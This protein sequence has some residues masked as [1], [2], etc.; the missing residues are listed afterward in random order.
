MRLTK[1]QRR[2]MAEAR[3]GRVCILPNG[4]RSRFTPGA[5][6]VGP[7]WMTARV[8]EQ[9]GLMVRVLSVHGPVIAGFA[10]TKAG[11]DEL[12]KR[13]CSHCHG[14]G[15][16]YPGLRHEGRVRVFQ[17]CDACDETGYQAVPRPT[18]DEYPEDRR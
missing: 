13:V 6:A 15:G 18:I 10:L 9:L 2:F 16:T 11:Q 1:V 17:P 5:K 8:L 14:R 4:G 12:K 7:R 3:V